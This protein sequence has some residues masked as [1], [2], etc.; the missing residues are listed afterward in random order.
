MTL[1]SK[2][3]TAS[4]KSSNS[5]LQKQSRCVIASN[6]L[7]VIILSSL[8]PVSVFPKSSASVIGSSTCNTN[9]SV[10]I[11]KLVDTPKQFPALVKQSNLLLG[12]W[13]KNLS[14]ANLSGFQ[15]LLASAL[16]LNTVAIEKPLS[17]Y[18]QVWKQA[19]SPLINFD[20]N[21][22]NPVQKT[23]TTIDK[24]SLILISGGKPITIHAD[25]RYQVPEILARS[26]TNAVAAVDGTFFS[27]KY[28]NSNVIIGPVLSQVNNQFI[29][30]NNGEN[31][32]L[33]GRPLVLIS[34]R[35]ASFI[36]FDPA[37]HN[38]LAGVQEEMPDVTDAFVAGAF[39]VRK[40]QPSPASIFEGLYGAD[41][42]RHR[43]FWGISQEGVP[44]IGVSTKPVD[45]VN[46]GIILAKAGL[47]E[48][49]MLDSGASTSLAMEG[50]SLVGY[51]PR[52]VPHVVALVPPLT[53]AT[54]CT[55]ASR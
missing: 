53:S 40:G 7:V 13:V 18:T 16:P 24:V 12:Y 51:I 38:T 30:G 2:K 34:P 42:A 23:E 21:F 54:N 26:G 25:S 3:C 27:L 17:L 49:V 35:T 41:V 11:A 46:L 28:L 8:L 9:L 43:A 20:F 32:K 47:Q 52:P 22:N 39:L 6:S 36:P 44:V 14:E 45:S 37:K 1:I 10:Q 55:L 33:A 5:C 29:P 31:K 19:V 48:A 15:T 50:R 4:Y